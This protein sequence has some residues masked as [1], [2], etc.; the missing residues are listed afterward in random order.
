MD[1]CLGQTNY[2]YNYE[3]E[4]KPDSFLLI[5]DEA[6]NIL[7]DTFLDEATGIYVVEFLAI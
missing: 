4:P 6:T 2:R 5:R 3:L 1:H 7:S